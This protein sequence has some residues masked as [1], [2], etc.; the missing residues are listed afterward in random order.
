M[1]LNSNDYKGGHLLNRT[2]RGE[3]LLVHF[4]CRRDFPAD[5]GRIGC[6]SLAHLCRVFLTRRAVHSYEHILLLVSPRAFP[7]PPILGDYAD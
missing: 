3:M 5:T 4:R 2:W 6:N 1:F 7:V